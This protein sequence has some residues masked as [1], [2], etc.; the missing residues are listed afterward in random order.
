MLRLLLLHKGNVLLHCCHLSLGGRH[1]L[2]IRL[3]VGKLVDHVRVVLIDGRL[4]L[5]GRG[6]DELG[7]WLLMG[8]GLDE[9]GGSLSSS[10]SE[11]QQALRELLLQV[12]SEL[13]LLLLLLLPVLN[14]TRRRNIGKGELLPQH[15]LL[16]VGD[17]QSVE[18][19]RDDRGEGRHLKTGE[20]EK[21]LS[22]SLCLSLR[23]RLSPQPQKR[24]LQ[25]LVENLRGLLFGQL[26]GHS[27]WC[28]R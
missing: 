14:P 21:L 1:H 2:L 13:D 19:V 23:L 28:G 4:W 8:R 24:S 3:V 22:L 7:C 25:C 10:S 12:L 6:L 15:L 16:K 5:R 20:L 11:G 17:S 26:E 27:D 9:L 18:K